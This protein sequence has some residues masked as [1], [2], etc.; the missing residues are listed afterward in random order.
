MRFVEGNFLS[1]TYFVAIYQFKA[2][3]VIAAIG[4]NLFLLASISHF[5]FMYY[6]HYIL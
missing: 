1:L 3:L 6:D 2:R 5:F 4:L